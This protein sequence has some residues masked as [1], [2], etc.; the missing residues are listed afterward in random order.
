LNTSSWLLGPEVGPRLAALRLRYGELAHGTADKSA[1][2]HSWTAL[3][4]AEKDDLSPLLPSANDLELLANTIAAPNAEAPL[5]RLGIKEPGVILHNR[6]PQVTP[7]LAARV[8]VALSTL[9]T[10]APVLLPVWQAIVVHVI[11]LLVTSPTPS[12]RFGFSSHHLKGYIF[13]S[14]APPKTAADSAT[15]AGAD[16]VALAH[17]LGHQVLMTYQV[18]D[19]IIA[20]NPDAPVYSAIR[21]T[22]R[23]AILAFHGAMALAYMTHVAE[24]LG[25]AAAKYYRDGLRLTLIGLRAARCQYTEL[26]ALLAS[27]LESLV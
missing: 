15:E 10:A 1:G 4:S 25:I 13:L 9:F 11:P 12:R 7:A 8:A 16:A 2:A 14:F 18:A 21:G 6:W 3:N 22:F 26:G 19:P 20:S 23:P 27:E 17:E 24:R 5:D